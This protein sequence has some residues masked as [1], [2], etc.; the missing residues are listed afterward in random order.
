MLSF[1]IVYVSISIDGCM[2]QIRISAATLDTRFVCKARKG[3]CM[4]GDLYPY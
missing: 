1:I 2:S 4:P 3:C